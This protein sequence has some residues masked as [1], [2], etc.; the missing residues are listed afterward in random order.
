MN[1]LILLLFVFSVNALLLFIHVY[2]FL[3]GNFGLEFSN[4]TI[5]V[6]NKKSKSIKRNKIFIIAI[7]LAFIF[8]VN[9]TQTGINNINVNPNLMLW[10]NRIISLGFF[11]RS[12]GNFTSFGFTKSIRKGLYA[13]LDTWIYSPVFLLMAVCQILISMKD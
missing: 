5:R 9:L 3:G 1:F 10:I 13:S 2:W 6:K 7:L 11:Y 12:V 8:I 4:Y